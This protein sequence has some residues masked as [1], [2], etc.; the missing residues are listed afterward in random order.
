VIFAVLMGVPTLAGYWFHFD[1]LP[2]PHR[3]HIEMDLGI[4]FAVVLA[5]AKWIPARARAAVFYAVVLICGYRAFRLQRYARE[6]IQKIDIV[7][8]IEYRSAQWFQRN[9][10]DER[11][12]TAGSVEFWLNA[13]GESPQFGGGFLQGNINWEFRVGSYFITALPDGPLAVLWLKAFGVHAVEVNG[14]RSHEIFKDFVYPHKFDGIL[15][16]VWRSDDDAIYRVPGDS[17]AHVLRPECLVRRP[18]VN[19]L[20]V[21]E[22]R[23]FVDALDR[24]ARFTWHGT[25][26]ATIEGRIS[27]GD[28]ISVQENFHP[29]WRVDRGRVAKD[30]LGLITIEPQCTGNC[31]IELNY[32]GGAEMIVAT[33]ASRSAL[34]GGLVW[35]WISRRR[36]R[37]ESLAMRKP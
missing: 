3:Y 11:V 24:P 17:L 6:L 28:V 21:E 36:Q 4:C 10:P 12:M 13:F 5:A 2:Q 1:M 8:T 15:Q 32:N 27:P 19:G 29:G 31:R 22:M 33:W 18:P 16:E 23:R 35:I 25:H 26:A 14:P 20:D 7:P 30:G 37:S 34:V 9:M